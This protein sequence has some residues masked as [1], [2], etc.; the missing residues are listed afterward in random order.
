[1]NKKLEKILIN[2]LSAIFIIALSVLCL[3][4]IVWI[5]GLLILGIQ[6]VWGIVLNLAVITLW[7]V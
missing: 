2:I 5:I 1:M 6:S 4:L 3:A 7:I